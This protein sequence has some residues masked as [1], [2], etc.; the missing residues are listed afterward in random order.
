MP[1]SGVSPY[2]TRE[3]PPVPQLEFIGSTR[4][5]FSAQYSPDGKRIAFCLQSHGSREHLGVRCG[6]RQCRGTLFAS[7]Q[8]FG[9]SKLVS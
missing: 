2:Q 9:L 1:T 4:L 6:R 7:R 5:D 3:R 8:G